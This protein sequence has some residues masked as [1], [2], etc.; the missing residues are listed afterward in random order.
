MLRIERVFWKAFAEGCFLESVF[1]FSFS[2][3]SCLDWGKQTLPWHWSVLKISYCDVCQ[4]PQSRIYIA[5]GLVSAGFLGTGEKVAE[6][7]KSLLLFVLC[8]AEQGPPYR[9]GILVCQTPHIT[10][11][12]KTSLGMGTFMDASSVMKLK[13]PLT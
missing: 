1:C 2:L 11:S 10:L 7:R 6:E 5:S 3:V 4:R 12:C 8:D 9:S 13:D